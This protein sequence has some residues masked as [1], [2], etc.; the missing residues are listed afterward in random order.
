M[1]EEEIDVVTVGR[2]PR[3]STAD[4]RAHHHHQQQQEEDRGER[5]VASVAGLLPG[6]QGAEAG[7]LQLR[8]KN[9]IW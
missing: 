3:A 2:R 5:S 8:I 6:L 9:S 7:A 4:L 1:A